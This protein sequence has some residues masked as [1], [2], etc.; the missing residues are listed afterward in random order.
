MNSNTT[1]QVEATQEE[2][3]EQEQQAT[4]ET[5]VTTGEQTEN[6]DN[7]PKEN[8]VKE[9]E[10]EPDIKQM[11]ETEKKLA[12]DLNTKGVDFKSLETEFLDNGKLSQQSYE[13]LE[14]AG[15]PKEV[16]NGYLK[17]VEAESKA[18]Y[19]SVI[20]SAGS[21]QEYQQVMDFVKS[22]GDSAIDDFN[23]AINS[24]NLG[25]INMVIKGYKAEMTATNGTTNRT[26]IGGSSGTADNTTA[27]FETKEEMVKAM[28]DTRYGKDKKYTQEVEQRTEQAKFF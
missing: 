1:T 8:E 20:T 28:S 3:Q 7:A 23:S 9:K 13:A 15:Y 19:N 26:L 18:F 10:E 21:E 24:G 4:Q 12:D 22:K 27:G 5:E 11:Q 6:Q 14:K 16:V 2:V 17:G 25:I